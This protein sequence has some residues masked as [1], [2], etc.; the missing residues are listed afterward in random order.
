MNAGNDISHLHRL[1]YIFLYR[2]IWE[3]KSNPKTSDK[4]PFMTYGVNLR[5]KN[6]FKPHLTW[7]RVWIK[8][9]CMC[10]HILLLCICCF[11]VFVT[12]SHIISYMRPWGK[13]KRQLCNSKLNWNLR[14]TM[15][16]GLTLTLNVPFRFLLKDSISSSFEISLSGWI[17][18]FYV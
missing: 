11:Y 5:Q 1:R 18:H 7:S 6:T 2:F 13:I 10:T 15:Y 14:W 12:F 16:A 9:E 8:C 4:F 3:V 17:P